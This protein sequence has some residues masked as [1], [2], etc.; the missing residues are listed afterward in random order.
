[1]VRNEGGTPELAKLAP[2]VGTAVQDGKHNPVLSVAMVANGGVALLAMSA[3]GR[4]ALMSYR[5]LNPPRIAVLPFPITSHA[6]PKRGPKL[7]NDGFKKSAGP[8]V[9]AVSCRI[10]R[11]EEPWP[12]TSFSKVLISYRRPTSKVKRDVVRHSSCP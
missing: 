2:T 7:R 1:M 4:K 5:M 9:G 6:N 8:R 3:A 11:T 12:L 10:S